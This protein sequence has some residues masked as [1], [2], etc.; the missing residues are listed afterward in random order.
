MRRIFGILSVC[1]LGGTLCV[2]LADAFVKLPYIKHV[3]TTITFFV[4]HGYIHAQPIYVTS[5][6]SNEGR[7]EIAVGG[8]YVPRRNAP[9]G[10]IS[11]PLLFFELLFA[12]ATAVLLIAP[13]W[14]RLLRRR[15]GCCERCGYSL[16]GLRGI[17][18]PECAFSIRRSG[19][20]PEAEPQRPL[21]VRRVGYGLLPCL[22]L[23]ILVWGTHSV[24]SV[25]RPSPFESFIALRPNPNAFAVSSGEVGIITKGGGL[26]TIE[27]SDLRRSV[28]YYEARYWS[29]S[30]A[31]FERVPDTVVRGILSEPS[32]MTTISIGPWTF[33]WSV[34]DAQLHWIY[35]PDETYEVTV[36][37]AATVDMAR[38]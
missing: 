11:L 9:I 18:C 38:R 36:Q 35:R 15:W 5:A 22:T 23:L 33:E 3:P 6:L 7:R 28:C 30:N 4:R 16:R 32:R 14:R 31:A 1:L 17:V 13:G 20:R 10:G 25:R 34:G 8:P 2:D 27:I 21:R 37:D 19:A 26:A 12:F 24:L 29:D